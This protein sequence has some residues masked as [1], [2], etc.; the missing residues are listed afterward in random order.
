MSAVNKE[1]RFPILTT[2]RAMLPGSSDK[3]QWEDEYAGGA[4]QGLGRGS[5]ADRYAII[6]R[7]LIRRG[8]ASS[9]LDVGCGS[10]ALLDFVARAD[11][12]HYTGVDISEEAL[13]QAQARAGRI[14][15]THFVAST[16][17]AYTPDRLY[18][19]IVFNE[20][21]FYLQDPRAVLTSY[22]RFLAPDGLLLVSML[23]CPL[24]RL[25]WHKLSR[26]FVTTER[27]NVG[28]GALSWSVRALTIKAA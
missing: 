28:S 27:T 5:D 6:L 15:S 16:A 1:R 9:V 23:D 14:P 20:V 13:K 26:G 10:G 17:E 24:A 7:H 22:Q 18:D 3:R 4:W 25:L 11:L 8:S 21:V 19:V 12:T 2:L